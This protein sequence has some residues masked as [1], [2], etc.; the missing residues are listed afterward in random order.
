MDFLATHFDEED[1]M[2]AQ[3]AVRER[4]EETGASRPGSVYSLKERDRRSLR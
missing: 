4:D 3:Q 2:G 1:T